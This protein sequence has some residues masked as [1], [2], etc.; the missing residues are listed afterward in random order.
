MPWLFDVRHRHRE[1]EKMDQ[2]DL[3]PQ[4]HQDAL[5]GLERINA[6]SGSARI[7]WPAL[8]DLARQT[9]NPLRV[10]DVATGAGDVP[11]WLWC[12]T[13]RAGLEIHFAGCDRS[14]TALAF[15]RS[16]A[17]R[18][19]ANVSFFE[20]DVLRGPLPE[21]Y[22]VLTCS[23]FLHH[24][25]NDQAVDLLRRMGQAAERMVLVNDLRRGAGGLLLAYVGTRIFSAS[26][27]VHTDGP[28]SV[29]AA[30]TLKE[31]A[32]LARQAGLANVTLARRWPCRFILSWR[33]LAHAGHV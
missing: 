4:Q 1:P 24:L 17:E 15:A 12:R 30:F 5:C 18:C 22:D 25:E 29:R 13:R 27:I 11:I 7:L 14:P 19:W 16:R 6:W 8:R 32:E 2:P 33:T 21:G 23:L 28:L 20:C 26:S 10:L 3:D 9:P 31:V